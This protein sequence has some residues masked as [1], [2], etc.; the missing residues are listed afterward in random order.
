[1]S[2]ESKK[3]KAK[4]VTRGVEFDAEKKQRRAPR[5]LNPPSPELKAQIDAAK[6]PT[7]DESNFQL[8]HTG[9]GA[10]LQA[11]PLELK[12][13]TP[14]EM[15]YVCGRVNM[16]GDD[17]HRRL[18]EALN[19]TPPGSGWSVMELMNWGTFC[20]ITWQRAKEEPAAAPAEQTS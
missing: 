14:P 20:I 12:A 16:R 17:S 6:S 13:W 15:E 4:P 5:K 19:K 18:Q 1:M 7:P 3:T 2:A 10:G 9:L 11:F 8:L